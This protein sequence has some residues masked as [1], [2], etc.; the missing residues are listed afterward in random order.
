M[1]FLQNLPY[2]KFGLS[3]SEAI[4]HAI[5]KL[6]FGATED[7]IQKIQAEGLEQWFDW[8]NNCLKHNQ[9]KQFVMQT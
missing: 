8:V 1:M 9:T 3:E 6:T 4:T 7:L 2:T 5:S